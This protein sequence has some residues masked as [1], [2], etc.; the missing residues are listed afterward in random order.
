M[1]PSRLKA[2]IR[3]WP[4]SSAASAPCRFAAQDLKEA[5]ALLDDQ[6]NSLKAEGECRCRRHMSMGAGNGE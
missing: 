5:K 4:K 3:L 6:S 2:A 1:T